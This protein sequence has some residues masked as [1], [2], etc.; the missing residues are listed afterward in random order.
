MLHGLVSDSFDFTPS[1]SFERYLN[2]SCN[3]SCLLQ[4]LRKP[5]QTPQNS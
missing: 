2:N 4:F 3:K 5:P 1:L